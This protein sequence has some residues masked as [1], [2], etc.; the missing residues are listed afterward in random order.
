MSNKL[1]KGINEE[2]WRKF[3][4]LLKIENKRVSEKVEEFIDNYLK[5]NMKRLF[6]G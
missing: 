5:K 1:I 3:V 4:A 6:G 2:K